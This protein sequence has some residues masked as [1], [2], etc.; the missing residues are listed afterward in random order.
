MKNSHI[1]SALL[2]TGF[3]LLK[4]CQ[5]EDFPPVKADFSFAPKEGPEAPGEIVFTDLS[6]NTGIYYWQYKWDF[7]DTGTSQEENPT[8]RYSQPGSYQVTLTVSGKYGMD[9]VSK[10]VI[11]A[12]P[13]VV[14]DFAIDQTED[15]QAPCQVTF[16]NLSVNATGYL[17]DFGDGSAASAEANPAHTYE[18]HG[19]YLVKLTAGN[20]YGQSLKEQSLTI[21]AP[22]PPVADFT[23]TGGDCEAPC[24]VTFTNSSTGRLTAFSWDFGDG[25]ISDEEHPRH[26]Y[27]A[28]GTYDVKLIATGPGGDSPP[29]IIKVT[30]H[31][32]P[33]EE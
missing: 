22:P 29:K 4:S 10:E 23:V 33:V 8:H 15:C 25:T 11:I 26:L 17:W 2:L 30:I 18:R 9:T 14:A 5:M 3:F 28:A 16:E 32:K 6:Q 20:E 12:A 31:E 27:A 1:L 21:K 24:E 13:E 19:D 7:G